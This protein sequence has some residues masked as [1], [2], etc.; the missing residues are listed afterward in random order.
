MMLKARL[1]TN[2]REPFDFEEALLTEFRSASA[3]SAGNRISLGWA[4][5]FFRTTRAEQ[6]PG[7]EV[8]RDLLGSTG[9]DAIGTAAAVRPQEKTMYD[10]GLASQSLCIEGVC[11]CNQKITAQGPDFTCGSAA[12]CV[13]GVSRKD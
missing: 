3:N 7:H 10:A 1:A 6:T 2:R 5:R 9:A 11:R 4:G 13:S 12:V 8:G